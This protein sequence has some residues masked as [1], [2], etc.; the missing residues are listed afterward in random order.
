MS[1]WAVRSITALCFVVH[2]VTLF[3]GNLAVYFAVGTA[4]VPLVVF[5]HVHETYTRKEAR[6]RQA[7]MASVLRV[8]SKLDQNAN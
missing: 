8:K 4:S 6:I 1:R 2:V 3:S 7:Q 5:L